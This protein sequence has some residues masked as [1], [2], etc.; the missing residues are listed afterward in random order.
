MTFDIVFMLFMIGLLLGMILVAILA[1]PGP[2][3]PKHSK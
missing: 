2:K 3:K 1:Y